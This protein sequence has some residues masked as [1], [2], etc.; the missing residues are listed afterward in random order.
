MGSKGSI[1]TLAASR[2]VAMGVHSRPDAS[3]VQA[4]RARRALRG[5]PPP[6][7]LGIS[8]IN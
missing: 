6:E 4:I 1:R 8:N 5:D 7:A 2:W 3:V